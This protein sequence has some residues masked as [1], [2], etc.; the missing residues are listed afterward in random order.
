M[1][2]VLKIIAATQILFES[3]PVSSSGHVALVSILCEQWFGLH[4]QV[5][6]ETLD[7]FLHGSVLI[8]VG[9]Y[10][11]RDWRSILKM[12][13]T[14]FKS[15]KYRG[16]SY[17]VLSDTHKKVLAYAQQTIM[18]I[19]VADGVML[20][21]YTVM[22]KLLKS[23]SFYHSP[24]I[25]LVGFCT[26][27]LILFSEKV[28]SKTPVPVNDTRDFFKSALFIGIVQSFSFFPGLSRF[29]SA[30][31]ASRFFG[32][33][34]RRALQTS[35]LMF[36]PLALAAFLFH[37]LFG[38]ITDPTF[39]VFL[40]PSWLLFFVVTTAVS[41]VLFMIACHCVLSQRLWLFGVYM[42]VPIMCLIMTLIH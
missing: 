37:G 10:F 13:I 20:V 26:T 14:V 35:F 5:L 18:F 19:A 36:Y 42:I 8:I 33:K 21:V 38:C 16:F 30:Y 1:F 41:H 23:T 2:D 34:P 6:S 3:L 22:K 4:P 9:I 29:A 27:A 31:I 12:L 7:H 24:Y 28:I 11:Y 25:L 17:S 40:A 39:Q 15:W 32:M